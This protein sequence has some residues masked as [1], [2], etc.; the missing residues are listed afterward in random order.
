MGTKN[1]LFFSSYEWPQNL[2]IYLLTS[3]TNT[4]KLP[5]VAFGFIVPLGLV[6]FFTASNVKFRYLQIYTFASVISV[7]AF[8]ITGRYRLPATAGFIL[9][10]SGYL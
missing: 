8:F 1:A 3:I 7:V 9:L 2:N 4:L 10:A 5:L 6:G